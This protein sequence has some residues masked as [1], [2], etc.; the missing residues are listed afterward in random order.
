MFA[1]PPERD[2]E[3]S[4]KGVE[5]A[6]RFLNRVWSFAYNNREMMKKRDGGVEP[7]I[8]SVGNAAMRLLRKTHQTIQRI[9]N[10]IERNYHFNTAIAALMELVNELTSFSPQNSA[11]IDTMRFSLKKVILLLSPFAPHFSE[12]LWAETG[13]QGSILHQP[14]PVWDETLTREDELELV[15]QINGKLRS[16]VMIPA[17][18]DDKNIRERALRDSKVSGYIE[19]KQIKKMI[20]VKGKLVNI[21]I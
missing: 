11:D 21:V 4:D 3:W 16:K 5:G 7:D 17:G 12:E 13:G 9:T 20:V 10:C 1:S 6:Y 2:L 18:L 15:V 19:G 8:H 14:W